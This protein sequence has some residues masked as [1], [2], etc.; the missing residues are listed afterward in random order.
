MKKRCF[1]IAL[2]RLNMLDSIVH[3]SYDQIIIASACHRL[4][5]YFHF[6]DC[7]PLF[8]G[9]C[10]LPGYSGMLG[11]YGIRQDSKIFHGDG[12]NNKQKVIAR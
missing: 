6:L 5:S 7:S 10:T 11:E 9:Y 1:A 3:E 8:L 4:I 12:N 2:K